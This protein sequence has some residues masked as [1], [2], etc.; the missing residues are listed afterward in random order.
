MR[1]TMAAILGLF[2]GYLAGA[3]IGVGLVEIFSANRHDKYVEA[4]T[5]AAFVTGPLGALVGSL[6]GVLWARRAA[7]AR[8]TGKSTS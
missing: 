4:V 6:A 5:T 7:R 2:V 3:V 1:R 8:K